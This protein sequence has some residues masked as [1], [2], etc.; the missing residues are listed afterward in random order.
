MKKKE[1]PMLW[2]LVAIG[3]SFLV[4]AVA[5]LMLVFTV[6]K[7]PVIEEKVKQLDYGYKCYSAYEGVLR[8]SEYYEKNRLGMEESYPSTLIKQIKVITGFAYKGEKKARISGTLKRTMY[9]QGYVKENGVKTVV[10]KKVKSEFP[11]EVINGQES[12]YGYEKMLQINP[13]VYIQECEQAEEDFSMGTNNEIV[14][15]LK[16]SLTVSKGETI[17]IP[18]AQKVAIPITDA[19][20]KV[21]KSKDA[22]QNGTLYKT[23]KVRDN[24]NVK[25]AVLCGGVAVVAFITGIW[26]LLLTCSKAEG[27]QELEERRLRRR[28]KEN[29]FDVKQTNE[30]QYEN[31]YEMENLEELLRFAQQWEV[32]VFYNVEKSGEYYAIYQECRVEYHKMP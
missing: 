10:W 1:L 8:P 18:V 21:D 19:I 30:V 23:R 31:C 28:H 2:R 24:V 4:F 11:E 5:V 16:G 9:L 22:K 7:R 25:K 27:Q 29:I 13:A 15:E 6:L 17:E 26:L 14:V 32:P 20:Y 3:C 12:V